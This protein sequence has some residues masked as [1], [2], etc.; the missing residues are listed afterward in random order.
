MEFHAVGCFPAV[1]NEPWLIGR[2]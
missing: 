1:Q 2:L